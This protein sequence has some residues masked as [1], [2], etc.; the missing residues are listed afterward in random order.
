MIQDTNATLSL[1]APTRPTSIRTVIATAGLGLLLGALAAQADAQSW[2]ATQ[3]DVE[4]ARLAGV[5]EY[6]IKPVASGALRWDAGF[7][8][9]T[10]AFL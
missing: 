4:T 10:T 9:I 1:A 6:A 8:L 2:R 7:A 5:H 3:G